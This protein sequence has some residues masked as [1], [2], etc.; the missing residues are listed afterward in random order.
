MDVHTPLKRS[1][2]MSRIKGK[3]TTPELMVR[4]SLWARG[5]RYRLHAK[6]LPGKPDIILQRYNAVIFV[7][8]CFWHRHGCPATTTPATRREFWLGKFDDNVAR[9][10][11]NVQMLVRMGWRV[12]VIWECSVRGKSAD[13][14]NA[15]DRATEFLN[16]AVAIYEI[17][18]VSSS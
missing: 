17:P 5:Y 3:N 11:R 18:L 12:L 2:N 13:V 7:H 15:I 4:R 8:G 16:S 14:E 6:H 1:Y 9:D 10:R